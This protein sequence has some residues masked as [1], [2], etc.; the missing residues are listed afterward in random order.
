MLQVLQCSAFRVLGKGGTG[1]RAKRRRGETVIGEEMNAEGKTKVLIADD[2][3]VVV[4]GI[5]S[6]LE[7][8]PEFEIVGSASDG[9]EVLEKVES[10]MP[11]AVIMDISM[12]NM[13]GI[14][15]ACEIR[16]LHEKVRI[17]IFTMHSDREFIISLFRAGVSGYVL[18]EEPISDLIMALKSAQSG[19]TFFAD[20]VRN[21][22]RSYLEEL[23]QPRESKD[24]LSRLS[25]REQEVF[26]L[27]ADGLST[28]EIS[29]RLYISPKT[30]E[31]HKYNIM[32]K[33]QVKSI[34]DL[35]KIAIQKN[36]IKL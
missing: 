22:I 9:L 10:L 27:L 21:I 12:P 5:R 11:D 31:T 36:L 13:D 14:Q 23:E 24:P 33:L 30:V 29:K 32:E 17:I 4:E 25:P 3:T 16:K 6:A 20:S 18:K 19:G 15:A 28:K 34:A 2:H 1:E 8:Y 7:D 26:P 35:T